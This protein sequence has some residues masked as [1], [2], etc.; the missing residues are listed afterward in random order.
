MDRLAKSTLRQAIRHNKYIR[1]SFPLKQVW[2]TIQDHK[3]THSPTEAIY[4]SEGQKT[5]QSFYSEKNRIKPADFDL[6][7]FNA[8]NPAM[9]MWPQMFCLFYTKHVTGCCQINHFMNAVSKGA[10]SAACPCCPHPDKTIA[11]VLV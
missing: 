5:A 9:T 8:L 6:V 4:D 10:I 1:S 2:I 3:V 7:D 11:H